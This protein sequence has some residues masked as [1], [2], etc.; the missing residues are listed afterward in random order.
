MIAEL[1]SSADNQRAISTK[2]DAIIAQ[3]QKEIEDLNAS[4]KSRQRRPRS[5]VHSSK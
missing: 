2:Q 4:L 3:Q 5:W 1:K